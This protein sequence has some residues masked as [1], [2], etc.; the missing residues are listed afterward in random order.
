MYLEFCILSET[1]VCSIVVVYVAFNVVR[2]CDC[3]HCINTEIKLNNAL[4]KHSLNCIERAPVT[5]YNIFKCL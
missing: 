3:N 4:I 1:V 5:K 2:I